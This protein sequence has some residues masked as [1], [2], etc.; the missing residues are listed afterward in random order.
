MVAPGSSFLRQCFLPWHR[1]QLPIHNF[2]SLSDNCCRLLQQM[3]SSSLLSPLFSFSAF[4]TCWAWTVFS[5]V[6][7]M[8]PGG[9]IAS[10]VP[11]VPLPPRHYELLKAPLPCHDFSE[12]ALLW[13]LD[14]FGDTTSPS[15]TMQAMKVRWSTWAL[16]AAGGSES[17]TTADTRTMMSPLKE[18]WAF[19]SAPA[20]SY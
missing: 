2:F 14:S 9:S 6:A 8:S 20:F 16:L 15:Y 1:H 5:A 3:H 10:L 12:G 13:T 19:L 7:V 17:I 11:I 18:T 4:C